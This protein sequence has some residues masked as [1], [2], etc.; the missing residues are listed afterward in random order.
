M[1]AEEKKDDGAAECEG[2]SMS[3]HDTHGTGWQA[4][5][6]DARAPPLGAGNSSDVY[7]TRY[8]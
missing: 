6:S 2:H 5:G 8:C 7:V 4:L 3:E 1:D